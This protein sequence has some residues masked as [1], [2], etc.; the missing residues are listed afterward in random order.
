MGDYPKSLNILVAITPG[1]GQGPRRFSG[2]SA[3]IRHKQQKINTTKANPSDF[4]S[5]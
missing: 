4:V 1:Q 3:G 5:F 2:Y